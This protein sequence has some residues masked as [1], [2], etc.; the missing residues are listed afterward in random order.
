MLNIAGDCTLTRP[1]QD[2]FSLREELFLY[3]ETLPLKPSLVVANKTDEPGAILS[4]VK[5]CKQLRSA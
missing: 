5:S 2:L 1:K 4:S 3:D